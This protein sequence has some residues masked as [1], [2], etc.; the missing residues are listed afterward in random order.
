MRSNLSVFVTVDFELDAVAGDFRVEVFTNPA[1]A[2]PSGFGEGE[3]YQASAVIS[4]TGSGAESFQIVYAGSLGDE[5]TL[6]ATAQSVGPVYGAT[7][8]FSQAALVVC[9]DLDSDGLC[10][11]TED[12]NGDLDGNPATN[13]G[14][15]TDGD[16]TANYLDADD[17]G[18][19]VLTIFEGADPNADGDDADAQ[20]T[21]G[22]LTPDYLDNNDDNDALLTSA[23]NPDPNADG[24]PADAADSDGDAVPDYLDANDLDGPNGDLDGDGIWNQ[25][26]FVGDTDGDTTDRTSWTPMTTVTAFSPSLRAQTP[27]LTVTT[28]TPKTPIVI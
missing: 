27:T 9:S 19:G 20:D 25:H 17:D 8:E 14:P 5:I 18:D 26:E 12:A 2:D 3:V 22:D 13:P 16:T 23:E 1:G 11:S 6:T 21:D 4:H 10:D 7:S 28:L 15:D 24:N